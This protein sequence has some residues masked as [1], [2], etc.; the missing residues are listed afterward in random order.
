MNTSLPR[1][2]RDEAAGV[3][4]ILTDIMEL[5][6]HIKRFHEQIHEVEELA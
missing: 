2:V 1:E 5:P 4:N 6:E 3:Y